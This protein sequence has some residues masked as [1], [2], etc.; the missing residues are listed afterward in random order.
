MV[1]IDHAHPREAVPCFLNCVGPPNRDLR[2]DQGEKQIDLGC[3]HS[4]LGE[5]GDVVIV[6][7]RFRDLTKIWGNEGGCETVG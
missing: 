5:V 7:H 4:G 2:E 1:A 6:Q 3:G